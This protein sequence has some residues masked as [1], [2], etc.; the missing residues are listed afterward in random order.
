V[1]FLIPLNV[2]LV[3]PL[4]ERGV[5][6][7]NGLS[8]IAFVMIQPFALTMA[9]HSLDG[10][11]EATVGRVFLPFDTESLTP[12]PQPALAVYLVV[13]L[14][15]LIR[16]ARFRAPLDTGFLGTLV[17][18]GLGLHHWPS[19]SAAGVFLVA[20]AVAAVV[21]LVQQSHR[22]AY[23]DELTGLPARRALRDQM[24]KLGGRFSIAM[25]DVDH[26]KRFNDRYGHDAGDQVLKMVA[27]RM[28]RAAGGGKP[29]RYGGEEFTLVFP[30][31]ETEEVLPHLDALRGVIER[32]RFVLRGKDRPRSQPKRGERRRAGAK[33]KGIAVTISIGV[34]DNRRREDT[35]ETVLKA[36]DQAL[37]RAKRKGRNRISR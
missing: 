29:F 32:D 31:R 27:S 26:F 36:A 4:K 11:A 6:T 34:A 30:G 22:L 23:R 18:S 25:L 8:R 13:G 35:P 28:A 1:A 16:W 33:P 5:L 14:L 10:L 17:T 2:L 24:L 21:A 20:T 3:Q 12:I 9:G 7:L 15:I 19:A 37:Y